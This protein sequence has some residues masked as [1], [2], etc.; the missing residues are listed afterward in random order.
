MGNE[1][2]HFTVS[3]IVQGKVTRQFPSVNHKIMKRKVSRSG[4]SNLRPS[5]YRPSALPPGQSG[6]RCEP[7]E[8]LLTTATSRGQLAS[9]K[10]TWQGTWRVDTS[11]VRPRLAVSWSR[12]KAPGKAPGEWTLRQSR[13]WCPR[14]RERTER[15]GCKIVNGTPEIGKGRTELVAKSSMVPQRRRQKKRREVNIKERTGLKFAKLPRTGK[16]GESWSQSRQ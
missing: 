11:V 1:V 9:H 2:S 15:A 13:Q 7:H 8:D 5:A 14:D 12:T 16:Y 10:N 6:S 3:L 4:E